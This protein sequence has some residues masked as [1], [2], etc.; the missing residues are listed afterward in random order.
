MSETHQLDPQ[1]A[2]KAFNELHDLRA[3]IVRIN[4]L[5]QYAQNE[6]QEARINAGVMILEEIIKGQK[7]TIVFLTNAI[8]EHR[9]ENARLRE[10]LAWYADNDVYDDDYYSQD[11]TIYQDHGDK[12]RKALEVK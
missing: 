10:A 8:K 11:T 7:D 4:N 12:A 2:I 3:E 5:L 6:V 1:D 9:A